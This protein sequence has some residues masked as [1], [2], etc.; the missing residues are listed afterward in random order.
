MRKKQLVILSA[1]QE[2]EDVRSLTLRDPAGEPLPGWNPGAHIDVTTPGGLTSQYSLCGG[3][4]G[5]T[6][7]IAAL[8][9]RDGKGVSRY[10]HEKAQPGTLLAVSAPRNHFEL[11]P[12]GSYLFIAGGIGI[13]PILPMLGS[14]STQGVP[15]R[16]VYGGRRKSSM[17]FLE[18]LK[19]YNDHVQVLPED[20]HGLLPLVDLIHKS[21]P[22]GAIYCCG[23]APLISAVE[24]IARDRK[25]APPHV[26]R[27]AAVEIA[28][29][30]VNGSF[31]VEL[32]KTGRTIKV[33][34]NQTILE[35]LEA[36]GVCAEASCR[37]GVCGTC[38]TAVVAGEIDHRDCVLSEAE[39][40]AGRSMM[41]C[42]SRARSARLTL[43]V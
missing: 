37:E 8:L 32:A 17:A 29:G 22:D 35:A 13:T 33:A 24:A 25:L 1:K 27:F 12:A 39:R 7:Q 19:R 38:E 15:W 21:D 31:E 16:L 5:R 42:V 34:A 11:V 4:P 10:L 9:K 30:A 43:D 18:Q 23:P 6:W 26:E 2:A 20:E 28:P 40:K 36:N 41:I 3:E 14:S